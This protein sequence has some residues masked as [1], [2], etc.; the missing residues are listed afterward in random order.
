[1]LD[2]H[3]AAPALTPPY[4]PVHV[5]TGG[6][7]GGAF[8]AI[9]AANAGTAIVDASTAMAKIFTLELLESTGTD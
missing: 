2:D 7:A 1:M 6:G 3:H 4:K 9:S 8:I 5:A